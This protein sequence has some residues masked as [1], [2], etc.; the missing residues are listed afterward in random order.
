MRSFENWQVGEGLA[1]QLLERA[2]EIATTMD[3]SSIFKFTCSAGTLNMLQRH[4]RS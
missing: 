3:L 1:I 2:S 4:I